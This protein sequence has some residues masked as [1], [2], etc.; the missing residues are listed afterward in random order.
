M[1]EKKTSPRKLSSTNTKQELLDAYNL[2]LEEVRNQKNTAMKP[3]EKREEK[4]VQAAL[5]SVENISAADV[6]QS[7][8]A[9]KSEIGKVLSQISDNLATEFNRLE[10]LKKAIS[11]KEKEIQDLYQIDKTAETLAALIEAHNRAKD[12]FE[13]ETAGRKAQLEQEIE[14]T[15]ATLEDRRKTGFRPGIEAEPRPRQ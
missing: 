8:A 9:L 7:I 10:S 1:T 4:T 2:L 3:E 12:E 13:E 11:F 6:D 5:A 14:R 15:R